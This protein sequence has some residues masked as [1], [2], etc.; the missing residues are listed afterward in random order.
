[1]EVLEAR[2]SYPHCAMGNRIAACSLTPIWPARA[3]EPLPVAH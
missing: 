2:A 1:M 3:R